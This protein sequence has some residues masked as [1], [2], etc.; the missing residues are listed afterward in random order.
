[1]GGRHQGKGIWG[2]PA[3]EFNLG[4]GQDKGS[5]LWQRR[6]SPFHQCPVNAGHPYSTAFWA[7]DWDLVC[8]RFQGSRE[9]VLPAA[10]QLSAEGRWWLAGWQTPAQG[11]G[12]LELPRPHWVL[13]SDFVLWEG[14]LT[15]VCIPISRSSGLSEVVP[16]CSVY[17]VVSCLAWPLSLSIISPQSL[18]NGK[19]T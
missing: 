6:S 11:R 9:S 8:S 12:C 19:E 15:W 5:L 7:K 18:G 2:L 10:V 14:E 3:S 17:S 1:M 13:S 16:T 4:G